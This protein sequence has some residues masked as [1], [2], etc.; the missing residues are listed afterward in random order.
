M[1]TY[2]LLLKPE[3]V[4]KIVQDYIFKKIG[5]RYLFFTIAEAY[6]YKDRPLKP[7]Y[8]ISKLGVINERLRMRD[9]ILFYEKDI[10]DIIAEVYS[11][12]DIE[13]EKCEFIYS[14]YRVDRSEYEQYLSNV[15]L[16]LKTLKK[17]SVS[18]L[19]LSK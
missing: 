13:V 15:K 4:K 1:E 18:T 6:Y 19:K 8:Y 7:N 9:N 14:E 16:T 12:Q 17:E 5:E 2:E 11:N 10:M 3:E